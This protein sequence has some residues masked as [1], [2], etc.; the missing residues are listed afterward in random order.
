MALK[1]V[2]MPKTA[3]NASA[4]PPVFWG[5]LS[6]ATNA[7]AQV[8]RAVWSAPQELTRVSH[9]NFEILSMF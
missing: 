4:C 7:D 3:L 8:F 9:M 5:A 1:L 2:L 6:A